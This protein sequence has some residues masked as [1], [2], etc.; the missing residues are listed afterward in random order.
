MV[1]CPASMNI[2][3]SA[4]ISSSVRI[5][6]VFGSTASIRERTNGAS[7][8]GSARAASRISAASRCSVSLPRR[9]AR[10]PRVG[11]PPRQIDWSRRAAGNPYRGS[12]CSAPCTSLARAARSAP[13]N[14]R[15]KCPQRPAMRHS[16]SRSSRQRRH[17]AP[18]VL[19]PLVRPRTYV[20]CGQGTPSPCLVNIWLHRTPPPVAT[21]RAEIDQV[22]AEQR[23]ILDHRRVKA[24]GRRPQRWRPT[25]HEHP[26]DWQ[27]EP[28]SG[29]SHFGP[30]TKS[31]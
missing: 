31:G 5:P 12:T 7:H 23:A 15:P 16:V 20:H 17:V 2:T 19:R 28:C 13:S 29:N 6:P 1:S 8:S 25:D 27:S 24:P 22:A 14:C 21:A 26:G 10:W 18:A 9:A 3:S 11:T 4:Q 30:S